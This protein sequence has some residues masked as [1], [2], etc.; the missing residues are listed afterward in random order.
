MKFFILLALLVSSVVTAAD[1]FPLSKKLLSGSEEDFL[2]HTSTGAF[3]SYLIMNLPA[4]PSQAFF[5]TIV[6][7]LSLK[8]KNRGEAHITVITP[9]EYDNILKDFVPIEEINQIAVNAKIQQTKVNATCLGR[10][11]AEVDGK[12][13][14]AYYVVVNAPGLVEVR[15]Q[16]FKKYVE[17]GGEPSRFDPKHFYSHITIG[18]T[19]RD[20]QE[21]DGIFKGVNSC[22]GTLDL[23]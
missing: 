2:P 16:I 7:Q 17:K 19:D 21:T 14:E 5:N 13:L 6:S 8:L 4:A 3:G 20:L 11:R 12:T 10:S 22:I 23:D 15:K 18:F 9:P 1:S